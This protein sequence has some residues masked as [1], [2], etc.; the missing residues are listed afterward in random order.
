MDASEYAFLDLGPAQAVLQADQAGDEG[1][2]H[3]GDLVR[4]AG[5]GVTE[6]VN[7]EAEQYDEHANGQQGVG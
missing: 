7:G 1:G 6:Q 4:A 3:Q 2:A 5:G